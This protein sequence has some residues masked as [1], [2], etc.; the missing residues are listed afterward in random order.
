MIFVG[1]L[2][3]KHRIFSAMTNPESSDIRESL[4]QDIGGGP[5]TAVV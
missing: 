5:T 1:Y 3:Q 4:I 2:A